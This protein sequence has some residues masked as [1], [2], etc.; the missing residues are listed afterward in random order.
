MA[1]AVGALEAH[2]EVA[3]HVEVE[4]SAA[5]RTA[6]AGFAPSASSSHARWLAIG[7]LP[8]P[9]GGPSTGCSRR[10]VRAW[11]PGRARAGAKARSTAP[12]PPGATPPARR[13][14]LP[15]AEQLAHDLERGRG[16]VPAVRHHHAHLEARGHGDDGPGHVENGLR[17]RGR[18]RGEE[19]QGEDPEARE[20]GQ[21]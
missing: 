4:R 21:T 2:R 10:S 11:V 15:L 19:A 8:A 6:G 9:S 14:S 7:G 16:P 12:S 1:L 13:A 3:L 5:R 20:A 18:G 17:A